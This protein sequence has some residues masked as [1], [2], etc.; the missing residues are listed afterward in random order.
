MGSTCSPG[1]QSGR[2]GDHPHIHGEH[3]TFIF[4][5]IQRIGSPPYTWGAL[6]S[7]RCC[8]ALT[9]IT[10]IYMGST[11]G[12]GRRPQFRED[13]PH[14]HGEHKLSCRSRPP[15]IGSPPYTWGAPLKNA[16]CKGVVRITPIYM[17]STCSS[18]RRFGKRR[19]H[20]HIH[21]E[22]EPPNKP[23]NQDMGSPP[24]TWGAQLWIAN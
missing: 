10:P 15:L 16:G 5:V 1:V 17:G 14:I 9:G 20:P 12:P 11:P 13:H 24:Y 8:H 4:G 18:R 7:N 6:I 22:H 3:A 21:G 23:L 2:Y 19:D